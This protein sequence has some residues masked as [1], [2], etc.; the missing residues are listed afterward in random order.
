MLDLL[1]VSSNPV[2][3]GPAAT[4]LLGTRRFMW[5]GYS[6]CIPHGHRHWATSTQPSSG[7]TQ[8]RQKLD[9]IKTLAELFCGLL[10]SVA[11]V[12][13]VINMSYLLFTQ[14]P[15]QPVFPWCLMVLLQKLL[16]CCSAALGNLNS[17]LISII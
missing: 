2:Y 13:Q 14:S 8:Y 5:Q 17:S 10:I 15:T 6:Y 1:S 9:C 12:A 4:S 16:V 11:V 3:V 7:G